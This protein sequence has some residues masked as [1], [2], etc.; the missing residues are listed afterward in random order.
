MYITINFQIDT[1]IDFAT[2]FC[3]STSIDRRENAKSTVSQQPPYIFWQI[4]PKL[5]DKFLVILKNSKNAKF[6]P[7]HNDKNIEK[8]L[9]IKIL[10]VFTILFCRKCIRLPIFQNLRKLGTLDKIITYSY[11]R[12]ITQNSILTGW[13]YNNH[14][15]KY[16]R[17]RVFT[18]QYSH[19]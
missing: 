15:I 17:I 2:A 6:I 14:C 13:F 1:T 10:R 5:S 7:M 16:A 3:I 19:V 18:E 9:Q 12:Y 8:L 11:L 4:M